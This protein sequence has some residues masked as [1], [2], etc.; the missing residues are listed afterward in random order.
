LTRRS[1]TSHVA[2]TQQR[3]F[4]EDMPFTEDKE[5]A[6]HWLRA[7][8]TV[9][10]GP[11]LAVHHD[12]SKDPALETFRRARSEWIGLG[13]YVDL[14]PHTARDALRLWWS[15]QKTYRSRSRARLSH[16]RAARL[17]GRWAGQRGPGR[18]ARGVRSGGVR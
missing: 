16:R 12:H 7:G 2:S 14:A 11:D 18:Q 13:M 4:R 3:P 5:W 1:S 6:L 10:V 17:L 15:D 9:V 8:G